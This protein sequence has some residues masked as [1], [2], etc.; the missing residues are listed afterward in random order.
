MEGECI[1]AWDACAGGFGGGGPA[2][3]QG[4]PQAWVWNPS[5]SPWLGATGH[6]GLQFQVQ[7]GVQALEWLGPSA[8]PWFTVCT[9]EPVRLTG[10]RWVSLSPV[11]RVPP[12][13]PGLAVKTL[14]STHSQV[15]YVVEPQSREL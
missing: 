3:E 4:L 7:G 11:F 1:Q 13:A 10:L 12:S 6:A 14:V 9:L 2:R 8:G 15:S 5:V